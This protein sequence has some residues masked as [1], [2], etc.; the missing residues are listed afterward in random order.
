M[1]KLLSI[2]AC[3]A[4]LFAAPIAAAPRDANGPSASEWSIGP[5]IRGRNYSLNMPRTMQ[6]RGDKPTFEFPGPRVQNGHVHYVTTP[7]RSLQGGRGMTLRYRVDAD[8]GVRFIPQELPQEQAA[9]SLYFQRGGDRWTVKTP[10]H[11]WYSPH[12]RLMPL[13]PGVHRLN[14]SFDEP[15]IAMTGGNNRELPG[16][17][18]A[19]LRGASNVGFVFGSSSTRGHGVYATGRARFT[20]LDFEIY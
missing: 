10:H 2:A 15:W 1:K 13:K 11:R 14:I 18:A 16:Q 20:V 19:A 3:S 5:I 17:F 4:L 8:P 6:E 7:V 12:N 9:V